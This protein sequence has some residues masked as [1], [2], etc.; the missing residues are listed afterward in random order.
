[1]HPVSMVEINT[2]Y[3]LNAQKKCIK[4]L[5]KISEKKPNQGNCCAN[6]ENSSISDRNSFTSDSKFDFWRNVYFFSFFP[7]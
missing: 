3:F 1:M 7:H 6:I 4:I 5:E 2:H